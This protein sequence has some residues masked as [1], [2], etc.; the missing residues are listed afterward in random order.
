MQDQV[1]AMAL[2]VAEEFLRAENIPFSRRPDGLIDVPG[3]IDLQNRELRALPDL[4]AVIVGGDFLCGRNNLVSL[5]GAPRVVNGDFACEENE[6][7]TLVG[8]PRTVGG[9]FICHSNKL[10]SLAGAPED[11][12]G[13]LACGYN[14]IST[15]KGSP[16]SVG[17]HFHCDHNELTSLEDGPEAVRG[18]VTCKGNP[19]VSLEFLPKVFNEVSSS[20]GVFASGRVPL[21]FRGAAA[22]ARFIER[23][24]VLQAPLQ[25]TRGL[26]VKNLY[27]PPKPE[28][29]RGPA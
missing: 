23:A 14:R 5:K 8:G 27:G 6:L 26:R 19:L 22:M 25:V 7:V 9:N 15:L 17:L 16:R 11:L 2:S 21:K 20:F 18:T 13:V 1:D 12:G 3:S 28:Y 4:S 29:L 24:T 10:S